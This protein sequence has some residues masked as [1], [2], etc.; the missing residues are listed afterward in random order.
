[1]HK[2]ETLRLSDDRPRD[3]IGLN[4]LQERG[5][6]VFLSVPAIILQHMEQQVLLKGRPNDYSPGMRRV[7]TWDQE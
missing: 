5:V 1:M 6:Q 2:A 3:E 4:E 7:Y